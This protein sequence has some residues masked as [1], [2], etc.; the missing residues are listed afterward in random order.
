MRILIIDDEE[1]IRR[2]TVAV[3]EAAKTLGITW[4]TSSRKQK[5]MSRDP[6]VQ[7]G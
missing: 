5:E 4:D 2:I 6:D 7:E 3:L 1:N